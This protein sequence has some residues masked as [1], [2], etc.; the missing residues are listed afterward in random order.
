MP[1][2][3]PLTILLKHDRWAT[4]NM[5][6]TCE[7]LTQEQFHQPFEM[8]PG[9]LHNEL[10]HILG[11]MQGWGDL[12]AGREQRRRVEEDQR[13]VAELKELHT[14]LADEL[15]QLASQHSPEEIVSGARAGKSYSFTRGGVLTHVTTHSMHHRAQCLNMLRQ[16]GVEPLPHSAV[17]EWIMMVD[18]Q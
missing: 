10:N 7:A 1:S 9:S 2:S 15:E 3:D 16:L 6:N 8:G 13:T 4:E 17:V 14:K 18:D 11:A 5:L 12:L